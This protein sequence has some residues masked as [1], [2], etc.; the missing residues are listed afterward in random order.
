MKKA[1]ISMML[2]FLVFSILTYGLG[3]QTGLIK[4]ASEV[5]NPNHLEFDPYKFRFSDYSIDTDSKK[6]VYESELFLAIKKVLKP[7]MAEAEVDK[8]LLNDPHVKKIDINAA[9]GKNYKNYFYKKWYMHLVPS[10][11][12]PGINIYVEYSEDDKLIKY[13]YN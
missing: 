10:P 13:T 11:N 1:V 3:R 5:T 9:N 12:K 2:I 4:P 8:I 6:N 7:G